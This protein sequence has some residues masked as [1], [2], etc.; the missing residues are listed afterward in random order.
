MLENTEDI[1]HTSW[2]SNV[3]CYENMKHIKKRCIMQNER[4]VQKFVFRER[5]EA[6]LP[7]VIREKSY[8]NNSRPKD[9]SERIDNVPCKAIMSSAID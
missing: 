7:G 1:S 9:P 5:V 2:D 8:Q 6:I 4:W 3:K